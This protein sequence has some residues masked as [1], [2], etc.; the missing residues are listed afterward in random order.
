VRLGA[1]TLL[2][3]G[4]ALLAQGAPPAQEGRR[5]LPWEAA[6]RLPWQPLERVPE[7]PEMSGTPSAGPLTVRLDAD[8]TLRVLEGKGLRRLLAGLPGRPVRAWRDGGLPLAEPF[9]TWTFPADTPL[10]HGLGA[11]AWEAEDLRPSLRGLLWILEDGENHLTVLH[12]ATGRLVHL[13][14]P[15]GERHE[16]AFLKDRLLVRTG[17]RPPGWSLPWVGLLPAFIHL[18]AA[19]KAPPQGTVFTPF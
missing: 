7:A 2:L 1:L 4:P 15:A 19:E 12:P 3:A 17:G 9:G 18:G 8:G 16:I 11:L 14:L 13:P 10:S 5:L 6:S